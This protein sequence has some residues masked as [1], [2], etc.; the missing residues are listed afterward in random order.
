MVVVASSSESPVV[1]FRLVRN[2]EA[3]ATLTWPIVAVL[4]VLG[5]A[6]YTFLFGPALLHTWRGNNDFANFYAGGKLA[7]TGKLYDADAVMAI[8][9][10]NPGRET[11]LPYM[12]LPFEALLFW[13]FAQFPYV[14][15]YRLWEL[16]LLACAIVFALHWP[17]VDRKIVVLACFWSLPLFD[18]IA[19]GQ[20]SAL[21]L[22]I[23]LGAV[24]A[25]RSGRQMLCGAILALCAVKIHL[26]LLLPI[27]IL[28]QRLWRVVA[29]ILVGGA[30]LFGLCFVA[31]GPAW[32]SSFFAVAFLDSVNPGVAGMPN[33]F[34]LSGGSSLLELL[35]DVPVVI[36]VFLSSRRVEAGR[37]PE[38]GLYAAIAGGVLIGH[39]SYVADSLLFLPGCLW[40]IERAEKSW[41]RN[42]ALFM[43]S[44]FSTVW[45]LVLNVAVLMRLSLYG[46][47]LAMPWIRTAESMSIRV[48]SENP[49]PDSVAL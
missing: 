43:L 49:V 33:T 16:F 20:D 6:L 34:S 8:E 42:L 28:T 23:V 37:V 19:L 25:L 29:G 27:W 45:S 39:H 14:T 1:Q 32:I 22:V 5:F 35:L 7:G 13:P 47:V 31:G 15:G 18:S 30:F 24:L 21:M 40:C 10:A 38:F 12:R 2:P 17:A 36:A 48:R 3:R 44:P 46:W 41:Q 9:R 4:S 26:F 11:I